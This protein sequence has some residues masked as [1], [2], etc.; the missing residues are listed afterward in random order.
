MLGAIEE[1]AAQV[2]R[3]A[4]LGLCATLLITVGLAFA[5][6]ALWIVLAA[7][8]STLHAAAI[9]G[10]VYFGLG[11]ILLGI[12]MNSGSTPKH[13]LEP[14]PREVRK[15]DSAPPLVQAFL[16]GLQ[17]GSDASKTRSA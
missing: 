4:A 3:R 6:V 8:L 12:M 7:V 9:I 11:L 16:Y 17:A 13:N 15:A 5:T 14:T 2:G 1:K 10:L